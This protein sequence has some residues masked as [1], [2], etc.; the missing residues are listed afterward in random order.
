MRSLRPAPRLISG[1]TQA[2]ALLARAA[3]GAQRDTAAEDAAAAEAA[4]RTEEAFFSNPRPAQLGIGAKFVQHKHAVNSAGPRCC[5]AH[6]RVRL[7]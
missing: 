7:R 3:G 1:A 2:E 5:S 6:A 4:R